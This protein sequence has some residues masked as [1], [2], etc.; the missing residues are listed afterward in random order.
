MGGKPDVMV[1][2]DTNKEGIAVAEANKLN[3]PVVAVIDSNSSP[4]GI[5]YP[6][7]GN[8]DA[9]RAIKIYCELIA[10]SVLDG[11]QQEVVASGGDLGEAVDTPAE[12]LSKAAPAEAPAAEVPAEAAPVA[13]A[14]A[15]AVPVEEAAPAAEEAKPEEAK[16]EEVKPEEAAPAA[17]ET[18]AE[19][20]AEKTKADA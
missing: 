9:L 11:I 4:D 12:D 5:D 2:I 3:I 15:E 7:P 17:E 6:I 10:G 20:P 1:V 8:D 16:A 13:E 14:P 19:A 18:A